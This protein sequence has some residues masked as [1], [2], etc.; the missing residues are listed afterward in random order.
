M[1]KK[2]LK[3]S[4]SYLNFI[5]K[6]KKNYLIYNYEHIIKILFSKIISLFVCLF[7]K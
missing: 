1:L 7:L 2:K 6:K 3:V 5:Y 4:K